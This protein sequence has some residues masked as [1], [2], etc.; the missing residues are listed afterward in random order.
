ML[1]TSEQYSLRVYLFDCVALGSQV[2]HSADRPP[3]SFEFCITFQ[4]VGN[5]SNTQK[6]MILEQCQNHQHTNHLQL[7]IL[8]Y[9][10]LF[11]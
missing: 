3:S 6:S 8:L 1:A 2:S 7:H 10:V 5:S 9:L 11:T 4:L